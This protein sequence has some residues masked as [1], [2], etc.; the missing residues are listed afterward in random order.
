[1]MI[2]L[3]SVGAT[4]AALIA[5]QP[6][7]ASM[8]RSVTPR[9]SARAWSAPLSDAKTSAD[10]G[11]LHSQIECTARGNPSRDVFLDC[12]D[13][14]APNDEQ[15]IVVDPKNP[16]HMIASANDYDSAGDEFYTTFDGGQTWVTGDMSLLDDTR[17]GSDP[18]TAI[19]PR[20]NTAIHASLNYQFTDAGE[21]TNG[22]V[23]VSLSHDGGLHWASRSSFIAGT[24]RTAILS[25]CSTTSRGFYRDQPGFALLRP[26]VPDVVAFP[27]AQ[28]GV[29]RVAD[30]GVALG[31]RRPDVVK[32]A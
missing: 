23:V 3:V 5:A 6:A 17:T 13:A 32:G 22:H 24:G 26:H 30:L 1:M 7:D 31:R 25:K 11:Y 21:S 12:D 4:L 27:C 18:V 14:A 28:R 10:G 19:D 16:R 9:V 15:H 29:C 20:T 8:Q 2:R